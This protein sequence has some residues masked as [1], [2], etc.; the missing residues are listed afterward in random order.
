MEVFGRFKLKPPVNVSDYER[1]TIAIRTDYMDGTG[2][3]K[4]QATAFEEDVYPVLEL[5]GFKLVEA[6]QKA[7]C[8]YIRS[9][10]RDNK[11]NLYL[12]PQAITGDGKMDDIAKIID[13]LKECPTVY[14]VRLHYHEPVYDISDHAYHEFLLEHSDEIIKCIQNAVFRGEWMHKGEIGFDFA[15]ECRI[16]R[17][18]DGS[19]ISFSDVDVQTVRDIYMIAE[20]NGLLDKEYILERRSEKEE[21]MER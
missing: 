19:G 21:E 6:E 13:T 10:E 14:D 4:G 3:N 7:Y 20:K 8:P 2:W 12:H 5:A 16:P 15:R 17:I 1:V 18:G 9:V 11:L